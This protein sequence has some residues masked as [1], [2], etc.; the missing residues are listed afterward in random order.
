VATNKSH[1]GRPD[2]SATPVAANAKPDDDVKPEAADPILTTP[3][4]PELVDDPGEEVTNQAEVPS[5][6]AEGA[7]PD[8]AEPVAKDADASET[9][10]EPVLV[11][12]PDTGD[13]SE[14]T[15][16][17][18]EPDASDAPEEPTAEDE[19]VVEIP[20]EEPIVAEEPPA[21]EA[22]EPELEDFSEPEDLTSAILAM[23][24][25]DRD[26][27]VKRHRFGRRGREVEASVVE[28]P[29][30]ETPS[31]PTNDAEP[32]PVVAEELQQNAKQ[33]L[34]EEETEV[35]AVKD[36]VD[37]PIAKPARSG[38]PKA[39]A[40][41]DEPVT[42]DD[43]DNVEVEAV[44]DDDTAKPKRHPKDKDAADEE[45]VEAPRPVKRSVTQAPVKKGHATRRR[46]EAVQET[47]GRTTPFKFVRQSV[48]ELRKVVWP[49]GDQVGQYFIVVLVFV[50]FLM[51]VVF[52]LD[53]LFGWGLL[54]L[55]G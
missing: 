39:K 5:D 7:E 28:P 35:E 45:T 14:E 50:L 37:E 21:V 44:P 3:E 53:S 40:K 43:T 29:Y 23:G 46:D 52:G 9:V 41:V 34:A 20:A 54:K 38:R 13:L 2:A 51:F 18:D 4:E 19:P 32:E 27:K 22:D 36:V 6:T 12:E 8:T 25:R 42:N 10:S 15:V 30:E 24:H 26:E 55:F 1:D 47:G 16:A 49:T 33:T 11:D 31:G 48:A 17:V